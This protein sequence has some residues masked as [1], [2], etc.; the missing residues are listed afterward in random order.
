MDGI[1]DYGCERVYEALNAEGLDR[2]EMDS[3]LEGIRQD[4]CGYAHVMCMSMSATSRIMFLQYG[5]TAPRGWS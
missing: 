5:L 1:F 2:E 3:W 4:E